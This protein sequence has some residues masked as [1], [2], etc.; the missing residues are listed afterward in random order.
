MTQLHKWRQQQDQVLLLVPPHAPLLLLVVLPEVL[1]VSFPLPIKG[2]PI[3]NVSLSMAGTVGVPPP[4]AM[5]LMDSG[6]I[7]LVGV[8]S[9][10]LQTQIYR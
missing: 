5:I 4:V 1:N 6:D 7:V 3:M 10:T 9:K 8:L 2:W